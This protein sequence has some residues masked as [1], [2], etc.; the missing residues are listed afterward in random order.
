MSLMDTGSAYGEF[1]VMEAEYQSVSV[2][3]VVLPL[4]ATPRIID[5]ETYELNFH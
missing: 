5:E 1:C 4:E 3:I 2:C